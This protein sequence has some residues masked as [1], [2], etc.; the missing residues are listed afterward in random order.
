MELL[1]FD[2]DLYGFAPWRLHI[3]R[4][5]PNDVAVGLFAE[6]PLA[7]G[8][9]HDDIGRHPLVAKV[10]EYWPK[11]CAAAAS[12]LGKRVMRLNPPA[13]V[14]HRIAVEHIDR[15]GVLPTDRVDLRVGLGDIC[16]TH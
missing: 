16:R 14:H 3:G 11:V 12:W 2:I 8:E 13:F 5:H 15:T 7:I 10:I 4:K 6:D 1:V 9:V